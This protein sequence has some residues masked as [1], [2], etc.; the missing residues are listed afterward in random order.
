MS[1][2]YKIND[3]V[4]I[5]LNLCWLSSIVWEQEPSPEIETTIR[6][7][8]DVKKKRE[9]VHVP[10]NRTSA[11]IGLHPTTFIPEKM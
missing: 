4:Y 5:S 10:D 9:V 1:T 2:V 6:W 3:F 7:G 8:S 11:K